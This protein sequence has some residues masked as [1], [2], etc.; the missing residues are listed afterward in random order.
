[1]S[2]C[3][4]LYRS[5]P[6]VLTELEKYH[7]DKTNN[8]KLEPIPENVS[9]YIDFLHTHFKY[10]EC[11]KYVEKNFDIKEYDEVLFDGS[12]N[13]ITTIYQS[14]S[15]VF[16][17]I[18]VPVN[19]RIAKVYSQKNNLINVKG[20]FLVFVSDIDK[21]NKILLGVADSYANVQYIVEQSCGMRITITEHT[22]PEYILLINEKTVYYMV[23]V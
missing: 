5:T 12:V 3:Y 13:D 14:S 7:N 20:K 16:W 21:E 18:R 19:H 9:P 4:I 8:H 15:N 23:S 22:E 6:E 2:F 17:V 1:M 10:D 11:K